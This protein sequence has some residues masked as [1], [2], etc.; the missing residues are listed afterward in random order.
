MKGGFLCALAGLAAVLAPIGTVCAQEIQFAS[1]SAQQACDPGGQVA[2]SGSGCCVDGA[3]GTS[4]YDSWRDGF[5]GG[6]ELT[7][8]DLY[9]N[10]GVG[11]ANG[12]N[13]WFDGGSDIAP[14]MRYWLGYR[15]QEGLGIRARYWS[16]YS[17]MDWPD[18]FFDV[19]MFDLEA[20]AVVSVCKWTFDGFA[21][22]RWGEFDWTDEDG[23]GV[24]SGYNFDGIGPTLG[25]NL[26]RPIVNRLSLVGGVRGSVL[27]GDETELAN[28]NTA[29]GTSYYVTEFRLGLDYRIPRR[30]G[31]CLTLGAAWENQLYSSLSG[32]V[33]NDIDP[34]DIDITLAGP[35]V[36]I[37]FEH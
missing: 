13:A 1:Q 27:Y 34:E 29:R 11:E 30:N 37:S 33:D 12:G 19:R 35:V 5:E 22:A 10:H 3:S 9:A 31:R 16:Y 4:C 20:T 24:G 7:M 36:S 2:I 15:G 28:N 6:I 14:R 17:A 21:G 26:R 18:E 25:V 32:N 8:L 23:G